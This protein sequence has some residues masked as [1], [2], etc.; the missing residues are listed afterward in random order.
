MVQNHPSPAAALLRA[1]PLL[2]L[3]AA[4]DRRGLQAALA[5]EE[6]AEREKDRLYWEPLRRELELLRRRERGHNV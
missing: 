6:Q 1:R 3:A 4:R 2:S 5:A